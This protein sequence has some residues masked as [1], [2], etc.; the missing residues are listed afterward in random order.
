MYILVLF[1]V[2]VSASGCALSGHSVSEPYQPAA[3][4]M[5]SAASQPVAVAVTSPNGQMANAKVGTVKNAM[6]WPM[7]ELQIS[8]PLDQWLTAGLASEFQHAGF[9]IVTPSAARN[10]PRVQVTTR[11]IFAEPAP[12]TVGSVLSIP[13]LSCAIPWTWY[14]SAAA[15]A[16]FDVAVVVPAT[17]KRYERRFVGVASTNNSSFS[18]LVL[19]QMLRRALQD[20]YL[21]IVAETASLVANPR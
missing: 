12:S 15:I 17:G 13:L 9:Q 2:A 16:E 18:A 6:G 3:Q 20:D 10:A 4:P 11:Q 14:S 1:V 19:E 7:S 5:T 21:K 8:P